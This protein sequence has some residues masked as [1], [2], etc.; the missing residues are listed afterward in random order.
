[1]TADAD[2]KMSTR[3]TMWLQRGAVAVAAACAITTLRALVLYARHEPS[4]GDE[5]LLWYLPFP[6]TRWF[7]VL[8][9]VLAGIGSLVAI[10][11]EEGPIGRRIALVLYLP[12]ASY[13]L[14]WEWRFFYIATHI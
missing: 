5:E 11:T 12:L 1:M 9:P 13:M 10:Q 7:F 3:S 6:D 14:A 4:V 2:S 8:F